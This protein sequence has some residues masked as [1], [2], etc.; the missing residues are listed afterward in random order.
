MDGVVYAIDPNTGEAIWQEALTDE[1]G[2][3][4]PVR[5]AVALSE[6]GKQLYVGSENGTL[7]ALDTAD[8]GRVVWSVPNDGQ[9]Y[10]APVVDGI[11][12]Y[13]PI[14]RQAERIVAF[15]EVGARIWA[16]PPQVEE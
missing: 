12:I 13:Q 7:H 8:D 16:H 6:D 11:Y 15:N 2:K 14:I 1:N 9:I 4:A 3:P 5:A 10:S